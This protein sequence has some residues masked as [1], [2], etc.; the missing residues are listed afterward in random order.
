MS[1]PKVVYGGKPETI[2]Y[3]NRSSNSKSNKV[4]LGTILD[5]LDETSEFYEVGTRGRGRGG[6]V[7]KEDV[8]LKPILK[9]FFVD[10]GQGDGIIIEHPEGIM[11]VDAGPNSNMYHFMLYRYRN[12]LAERSI[13]IENIII[14]HPDYDHFGG[15]IPLI[16]DTRFT[17]G[18]I[19]HN[20]IQ[21]FT[22]YEDDRGRKINIEAKI[23]EL[24]SHGALR[25]ISSRKSVITNTLD[26]LNSIAN[27]IDKH[28]TH[29]QRG[30]KTFW[31]LCID[32]KSQNRLKGSKRI[33]V[34]DDYLKGFE[35]DND[36]KIQILGPIPNE[37][38]TNKVEYLTFKKPKKRHDSGSRSY[39]SHSH[40]RNGHSII[41]K[42]LYGDF[43]ILLG[44]DLNIPAQKH[45][46]KHYRGN[47]EVFNADVCKACHHGSAD[48]D[49][50]FVKLL[51]PQATIISSGDNTNGYDHPMPDAIGAYCKHSSGENPLLFSTEIGRAVSGENRQNTHYGLV[52][53]RTDGT[54]LVLAQMKEI[55]TSADIWHSFTVPWDGEYIF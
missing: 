8:L 7:K 48:Y 50:N 27:F 54:Q 44:G 36:L 21:R 43:S 31:N 4:L 1:I 6:Y 13:H 41:L 35:P 2:I 9:S 11:L 39:F 12:I 33:T 45:L 42:F 17:F 18:T 49:L 52:N 46:M 10:V 53:L 30:F 16:R 26:D 51:K 5:V 38:N 22:E 25:K 14:S 20:G 32:A 28:K 23:S 19:Y 37:L 15:L 40:T 47:L 29:V 34:K 24:E 55:R 3:K